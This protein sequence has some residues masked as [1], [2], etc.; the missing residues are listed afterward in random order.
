M[1]LYGSFFLLVVGRNG[2]NFATVHI[3]T[4]VKTKQQKNGKNEKREKDF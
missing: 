1:K 4:A 3:A 2:E